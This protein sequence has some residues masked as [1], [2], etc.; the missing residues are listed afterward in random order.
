MGFGRWF[1]R[2]NTIFP[3]ECPCSIASCSEKLLRKPLAKILPVLHYA[4]PFSTLRPTFMP[5]SYPEKCVLVSIESHL[6]LI[7]DPECSCSIYIWTWKKSSAPERT[8]FVQKLRI[9][10]H[11][12]SVRYKLSLP[13]L[14]SLQFTMIFWL[15]FCNFSADIWYNYI[16]VRLIIS[17]YSCFFQGDRNRW[18]LMAKE[19]LQSYLCRTYI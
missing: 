14:Y 3:R 1:R 18:N 2:K 7:M 11:Y 17:L 9:V 10:L 4:T 15:K 5:L 8:E 19:Q 6:I 16:H 12:F 13:I